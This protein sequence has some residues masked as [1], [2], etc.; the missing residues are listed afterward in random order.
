MLLTLYHI[1]IMWKVSCLQC[2]YHQGTTYFGRRRLLHPVNEWCTLALAL[3][4]YSFNQRGTIRSIS[5]T[6]KAQVLLV[7]VDV[8]TGRCPMR[9][10]LWEL[11][12]SNSL[13]AI[14]KSFVSLKAAQ[15]GPSAAVE[16]KLVFLFCRC[17]VW[18][19]PK[20]TSTPWCPTSFNSTTWRP[21]VS[22][23]ASAC[24]SGA[25]ALC[26]R[27]DRSGCCS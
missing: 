25:C 18:A 15:R 7:T 16:L 9:L 2:S 23:A 10:L 3:Q 8:V 21:S 5:S 6:F 19:W 24:S 13:N 20:P 11:W 27:R 4:P 17:C 12:F 1:P 26:G 14:R 22:D